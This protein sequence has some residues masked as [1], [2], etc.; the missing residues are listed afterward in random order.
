MSVMD[1]SY[2]ILFEVSFPPHFFPTEFQASDNLLWYWEWLPCPKCLHC[3]LWPSWVLTQ[4]NLL[5]CNNLFRRGKPAPLRRFLLH[6]HISP[7]C[8]SLWTSP[9]SWTIVR[10]RSLK[11]SVPLRTNNSTM[12]LWHHCILGGKEWFCIPGVEL[13]FSVA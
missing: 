4:Y 7:S 12:F 11:P 5:L 10:V 13:Q 3:L 6:S 1:L 9:G 2:Q 8:R